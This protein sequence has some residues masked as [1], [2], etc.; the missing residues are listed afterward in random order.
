MINSSIHKIS[1]MHLF[2]GSAFKFE[3][4]RPVIPITGTHF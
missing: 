2:V 3:K 4:S 1:S